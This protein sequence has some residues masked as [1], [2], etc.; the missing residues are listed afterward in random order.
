MK[1][2]KN[3]YVV[4][5]NVFLRYFL[6]DIEKHYQKAKKLLS[7]AKTGEVELIVVP[8]VIFEVNYV[9]LKVYSLDKKQVIEVLKSVIISPDLE[10]IKRDILLAAVNKYRK[11]NIDL[12]DLYLYFQAKKINGEVFSFDKDFGV[13]LE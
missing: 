10:V 9:L 7:Q 8:Q 1:P 6:H 4:D 5:T 2:K 3:K 11:V 13:W 12:I